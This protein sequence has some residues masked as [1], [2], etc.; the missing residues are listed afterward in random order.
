MA[1]IKQP[2]LGSESFSCPHCG[3]LAA[4]EW[5]K[6]HAALASVRPQPIDEQAVSLAI[7]GMEPMEKRNAAREELRR[8]LAGFIWFGPETGE[9]RFSVEN[10]AL[11]RCFA[12]EDFSVWLHDKIVFPKTDLVVSPN[13]DMPSDASIV[14]MEAALVV[15]ESPRAAA[16]LL[17]L[18]L[19]LI[20]ISLGEKGDNLNSD[21]GNLVRTGL[22]TR[23]QQ[24]LDIVRVVGNNAVHPGQIDL[25]DDLETANTLFSLVNLIV[26]ALISQPKNIDEAFMQLPPG[27]RAAIEKRDTS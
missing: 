13:E 25:Q 2:A 12:C 16:A 4:Q 24:A 26:E 14:F 21:I 18:C 7:Y 10:L 22:S 9:P 19:Q 11:S 1:T 20:C 5:F 8:T 15:N 23:V 27:A 17:R 3:A 6:C